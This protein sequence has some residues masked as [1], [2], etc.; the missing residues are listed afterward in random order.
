MLQIGA[1]RAN[2]S[3]SKFNETG[4]VF[5]CSLHGPCQFY[6]VDKDDVGKGGFGDYAYE[7]RKERAFIGVSMDVKETKAGGKNVVS[8]ILFMPVF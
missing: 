8:I 1:P 5:R 4:A 7:T 3:N 6:H 2:V